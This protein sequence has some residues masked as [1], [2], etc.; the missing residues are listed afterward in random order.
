MLWYT[1]PI[2][3]LLLESVLMTTEYQFGMIAH[4][5]RVLGGTVQI[6]ETIQTISQLV[7][8]RILRGTLSA[9]HGIVNAVINR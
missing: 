9:S 5:Q 3:V 4:Y 2:R 6:I 7:L 8:D 1:A